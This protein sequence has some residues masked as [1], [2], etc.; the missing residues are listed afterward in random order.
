MTMLLRLLPLLFAPMVAA[1]Q[2]APPVAVGTP[3][4]A[5]R[6]AL[7]GAGWQP[8][9]VPDADPCGAR[10]SRCQGRP[11]MVACSGTGTAPCIFAWRRGATEIEIVTT[12]PD[13]IVAATRPRR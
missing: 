12:G 6:Q 1:A 2:P 13:T 10:D 7:L 3:Y 11:E 8:L 4:D 9:R 5:A